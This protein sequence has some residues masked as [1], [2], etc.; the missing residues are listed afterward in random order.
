MRSEVVYMDPALTPRLE[1][2]RWK[3]GYRGAAQLHCSFSGL[4][5]EPRGWR[6]PKFGTG[7]PRGPDW[8]EARAVRKRLCAGKAV[9]RRLAKWAFRELAEMERDRIRYEFD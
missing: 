6:I 4:E 5:P 9:S 8:R 7:R 2:L 3:K 1:Y